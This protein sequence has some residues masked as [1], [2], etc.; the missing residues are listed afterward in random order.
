MKTCFKT[1]TSLP[2]PIVLETI[3]FMAEANPQQGIEK[4]NITRAID[5]KWPMLFLQVS[6]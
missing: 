2:R 5:W 1:R 3:V 4:P 6:Q